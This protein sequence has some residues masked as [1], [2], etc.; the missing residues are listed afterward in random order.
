MSLAKNNPT[1]RKKSKSEQANFIAMSLALIVLLGALTSMTKSAAFHMKAVGKWDNGKPYKFS[2]A[3]SLTFMVFLL[4]M[5][6]SGM[7]LMCCS[8]QEDEEDEHVVNTGPQNTADV[9]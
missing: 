1:M 3:L 9:D 5:G 6:F 2:Y 8:Q 4:K 7:Q